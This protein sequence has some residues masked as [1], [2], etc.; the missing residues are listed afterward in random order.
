V[1]S[2]SFK[3]RGARTGDAREAITADSGKGNVG[4]HEHRE[5]WFRPANTCVASASAAVIGSAAYSSTGM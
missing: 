3:A 4:N 1:N 5:E 2:P